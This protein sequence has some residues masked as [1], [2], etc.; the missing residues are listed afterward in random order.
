M[1][2]LNKGDR[3][4][5]FFHLTAKI[6][7]IRNNIC[8]IKDIAGNTF[9]S[10][11]EIEICFLD[12]YKKIC[13]SYSPLSFN[14]IVFALPNDLPT[15]SEKIRVDLIKPVSKGEV[16]RTL[17]SMPHGKSLGLYGLGNDLYL[18][19]WNVISDHFF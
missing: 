8:A 14:Q 9:T 10:I 3:N 2:W 16:Y 5:K 1:R 4:T 13:T 12:F 19:Y 15:L 6:R 11:S 17:R 18:L 7:K